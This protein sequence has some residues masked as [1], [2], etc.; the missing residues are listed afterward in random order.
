M[1]LSRQALIALAV[2][3]LALAGIGGWILIE[4]KYPAVQDQTDQAA[5]E[6]YRAQVQQQESDF[7]ERVRKAAEEQRQ[8]NAAAE[9]EL[10]RQATRSPHAPGTRP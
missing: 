7:A 3:V 9:Q 8:A 10:Q 4:W 1:V 5:R 6:R 2:L